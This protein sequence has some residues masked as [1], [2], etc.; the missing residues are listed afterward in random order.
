MRVLIALAVV[1]FA[2]PGWADKDKGHETAA[3]GSESSAAARAGATSVSVGEGGPGGA[4]GAGGGGGDGGA[5]LNEG[6]SV[7]SADSY[8]S[9]GWAIG[10]SGMPGAPDVG[11]HKCMEHNPVVMVLG[12]GKGGKTK[13]NMDCLEFEQCMATAEF[14]AK[15]GRIDMAIEQMAT[16]ECGGIKEYELQSSKDDDRD[17]RMKEVLEK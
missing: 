15:V 10:L 2:L 16:E 9:R 4:G 3:G 13:L 17:R 12:S 6:I 11:G 8:S 1:F 5:A 14:Y 7:S